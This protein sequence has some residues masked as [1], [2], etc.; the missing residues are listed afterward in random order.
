M[1][2]LA[3]HDRTPSGVAERSVDRGG[4]RAELHVEISIRRQ[5]GAARFRHLQQRDASPEFR[6]GFEQTLD[7]R[8]LLAKPF[9]VIEAIDADDEQRVVGER[10]LGSH[11][12]A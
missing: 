12:P 3:Q 4:A 10:L 11:A 6:V 8:D 5:R 9:R 7:D 1:V 2:H